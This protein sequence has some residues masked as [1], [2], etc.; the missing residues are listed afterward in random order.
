MT[1]IEAV[2]AGLD[3]YEGKHCIKCNTNIR[4]VVDYNCVQCSRERARLLSE[5]SKHNG[6]RKS[7][8]QKYEQGEAGKAN[9]RRWYNSSDGKKSN[10]KA[11]LKLKFGMTLEEYDLMLTN[12]Q[13]CCK[14]CGDH[15]EDLSKFLAVDHNHITGNVRGLLC[16][17]CNVALGMLREDTNIMKNLIK[18]V[19]EYK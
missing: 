5:Q 8:R 4:R 6:R 17:R 1:R 19:E 18:Y 13:G 12:Q 2:N 14:V 7:N 16:N 3:F 9:R 10:R 11:M 15:I